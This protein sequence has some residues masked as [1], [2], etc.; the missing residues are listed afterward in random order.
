MMDVPYRVKLHPDARSDL[1]GLDKGLQ[2]RAAKQ[3][4]KL[5]DHPRAGKPLGHKAG[6]DLTGYRSLH[7]AGQR[8][9]IVYRLDEKAKVVWV[10]AIAK[11]AEFE[12]YRLAAWRAGEKE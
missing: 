9:R 7:F 11:R 8:Y 3:L 4:R 10:I 2:Q 5:K 6:Y 1:A 12:A